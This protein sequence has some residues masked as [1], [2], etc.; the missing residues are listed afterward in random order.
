MKK[1]IRVYFNLNDPIENNIYNYLQN[2]KS[3]SMHVKNNILE[4][5]ESNKNKNI[6]CDK[7]DLLI[8]AIK[9]LNTISILPTE[10]KEVAPGELSFK[11]D[12]NFDDEY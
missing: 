6:V 12:D 5:I 2:K 1:E 4:E 10:N 9:G 11:L 7:L 8:D 3:P